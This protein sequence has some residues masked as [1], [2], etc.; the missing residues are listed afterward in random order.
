MLFQSSEE[1]FNDKGTPI[2]SNGD[3]ADSNFFG[4]SKRAL[5]EYGEDAFFASVAA[6]KIDNHLAQEYREKFE[7]LRNAQKLPDPDPSCSLMS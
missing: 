6:K 4:F 7:K 2:N 3:I 5:K 1:N